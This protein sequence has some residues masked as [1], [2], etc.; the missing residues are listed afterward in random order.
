MD[1]AAA[2]IPVLWVCGPPGVGKTTVA[3]EIHSRLKRAGIAAGYADIDQ[4]GICYPEPASDPGRHRMQADNLGAVVSAYRA[5]G[6]RCVVVSGVVDAARG[7]HTDRIPHAALTVC[8]LRAERDVLER[9]FT[10]RDGAGADAVAD[11]LREADALDAGG[12]GDVCVDTT[13][14]PVA[15]VA[16]RVRASTGGWPGTD[17]P[18]ARQVPDVPAAAGADGP[19]L[20]LCGAA[21][22]GK[23]TV[24]F[25][26]YLRLLRAGLTAA[27]LDLEQIG[28]LRPAPPDDPGNHRVK[29]RNLAAVWRTY[30]AAGARCLTVSGP[31]ED[32]A[33][34][35]AYTKALPAATFTVCRL[36]A[37]RE[38]LT[39]RIMSRGQGGSWA[40]PGDPLRGRST[41][42]L[43]GVA[44]AAAAQA[45]A[46]ERSAVGDLRID[47]DTYTAEEAAGTILT[48]TGWP[49]R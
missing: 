22:V 12:I 5:A 11:V 46:L 4:L 3:W 20:W 7:V 35:A 44:D 49:A 33:T 39:S 36:H 42:R 37:G 14:L 10:A 31:M 1:S 27:Y 6:A 23:S 47:T 21:G 18:A 24:G 25:A 30:R 29:A 45:R 13:G 43:L 17:L 34:L 38:Q 26:L 9:R 40:Q 41:A 2:R 32:A 19:V 16:R 15:E 8:R 48:R 28:F